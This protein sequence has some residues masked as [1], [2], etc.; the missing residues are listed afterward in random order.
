MRVAQELRGRWRATVGFAVLIGLLTGV[1]LAVVAGARRTD[2]AYE[3]YLERADAEDVVITEFGPNNPQFQ[4]ILDAIGAMHSVERVAATVPLLALPHD[5]DI[6]FRDFE[7]GMDETFLYDMDR[8]KV[9]AG[10]LPDPD[11]PDEVFVNREAEARLG[12]GV[13]DTLE[14][15]AMTA[16]EYYGGGVVDESVGEWRRFTVTGIGVL[17]NEVVPI[18]PFDGSAAV[19]FTPAYLRE[20]LDEDFDYSYLHIRLHDGASASDFRR[21]FEA[22]LSALDIPVEIVPFIDAGARQ[23]KVE[24]SIRP[25]ARALLLFG[26]LLAVIGVLVIGQLLARHLVLDE[27]QRRFLWGLGYTRRQLVAVT[28]LRL[29]VLL[30]G[31]GVVVAVVAAALSGAFPIGPAL[32]AEPDPGL[33]LDG[34][35][36]VPG[37]VLMV[38]VFLGVGCAAV[39]RSLP[40]MGTPLTGPVRSG[41]ARPSRLARLFAESGAPPA[42]VVGVRMAVERG[43]GRTAVPVVGA[44]V[45]TSLALG[46]LAAAATFGVNL[47]RLVTTPSLYGLA[48]DHG[49]GN[50]FSEMP[51][52]PAR[53]ILDGDP[54]V[55]AWS[56]TDLGEL[57]LEAGDRVVGVPAVGVDL[58]G[59]DVHPRVLRGRMVRRPDEVVLGEATADALGVDV[60]DHVTTA[61]RAGERPELEV[62]GIAVFP[63]LG[64]AVFDST[65]L[66][67]GAIVRAALLEDPVVGSGRHT[68]YL[69]RYRDGVD[70]G[71]ASER[72]RSAFTSIN[73]DCQFRLCVVRDFTPAGIRNYRRVRSTPLLL[74]AALAA[75]ALATLAITLVTSVR[76]RRRDFA[77]LESIGFVRGQVAASTAWQATTVAVIALS[78]GLPLGVAGGRALWSLFSDEIGVSVPPVMPV[79]F[80]LLVVPVTLLAAN[81]I[82]VVP[83]RLAARTSAARVLRSE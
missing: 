69:V 31:A 55:A 75:L 54:D 9:V 19:V 80:L 62:V 49:I 56:S 83:G 64:R 45:A 38:A 33:A 46:A 24:R 61:E 82:A 28:T 44:I 21:E 16:P 65:D 2:T 34:R 48:W 70:R 25:Q 41:A 53:R 78:V 14:L 18:A 59:A 15:R 47:Q 35:V 37:V 79:G 50:G 3:R 29:L 22:E 27:D 43:R 74:S 23:A 81:L 57:T 7:A 68:M 73:A 6:R 58:F 71:A 5:Q 72:L 39:I 17:P 40:R 11:R 13:G 66:A 63:G 8:P 4:V 1:V 12:L 32:V 26:A 60:G 67:E 77:V 52:A 36:L 76:R 10:R 20:H 30:G 42:A 51:I